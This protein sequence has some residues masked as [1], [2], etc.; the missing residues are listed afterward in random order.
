MIKSIIPTLKSIFNHVKNKSKKKSYE[1][2]Y[3]LVE[4]CEGDDEYTVLI[5][6]INKN[7]T[8][9]AKPEEL[10]VNDALVDQ[11]SPRDVRSLTYL[12][13]LGINNPKYKILA[14]RLSQNDKTIFVLKKKGEKKAVLKTAD[15][16]MQETSI[17][18]SMNPQDAKIIGYAVAAEAMIEEKQQK[19]ALLL[20][21]DGSENT[22]D[23]SI[24]KNS[25]TPEAWG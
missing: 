18:L 24:A 22:V 4:I 2:M 3:R 6:M 11:F 23:K 10:L 12:G 25:I 1:P 15:Q 20:N 21:A 17:I 13:Y 8:F 9:S 19:Q 16:I 5:Q 14:Q 7:V